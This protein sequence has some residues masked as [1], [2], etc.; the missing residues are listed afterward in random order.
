MTIDIERVYITAEIGDINELRQLLDNERYSKTSISNAVNKTYETDDHIFVTSLGIAALNGHLQCVNFLIDECFADINGADSVDQK[1]YYSP[2]WCAVTSGNMP[3]IKSLLSRGADVNV[4]NTDNGETPLSA[5]CFHNNFNIVKF[6]I[7][8]YN[9]DVE[10]TTNSDG[11]T[12]LMSACRL[13]HA[14]TVKYLVENCNVNLNKADKNHCT[15]LHHATKSDSLKIVKCL[16][17]NGAKLN[18]VD[19]FRNTPLSNAIIYESNDI[20]HYLLPLVD[21]REK[22]NGLELLGAIYVAKE[23]YVSAILHWKYALLE[24]LKSKY[25]KSTYHSS[26]MAII[27]NSV[28][29]FRTDEE[30]EKMLSNT[31]NPYDILVQALLIIDR[32]LGSQNRYTANYTK[33]IA[34]KFEITTSMKLLMYCA[35]IERNEKCFSDKCLYTFIKL[36][37]LLCKGIKTID[38]KEE[39][40]D[41]LL[42]VLRV[43]V[44]YIGTGI[45]SKVEK[46]E[47]F[48]EIYNFDDL[49][50]IHTQILAM[51]F[52]PSIKPFLNNQ[53]YASVKELVR[54]LVNLNPKT[55]STGDTLLHLTCEGN[56]ICDAVKV[57]NVKVIQLLRE[58]GADLSAKNHEGNTPYLTFEKCYKNNYFADSMTDDD[59]LAIVGILTN[60][61]SSQKKRNNDD[62]DYAIVKRKKK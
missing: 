5:A 19:L 20:T 4:V 54:Y 22:I 9:A 1:I 57:P 18:V 37:N 14:E 15:A 8:N 11:R 62:K 17:E 28:P 6:L 12:Y 55:I 16:A 36:Q 44:N 26:S 41:H 31:T 53:Q 59:L 13:G 42:A 23:M 51:I 3:V 33:L 2:L 50:V 30:L 34:D 25:T 7:E 29:E 35:N 27:F 24:R 45:I 47:N 21:E 48:K 43:G 61:V 56:N 49:L 39:I 46:R 60:N 40:I 38:D 10:F 32:I 52:T 58:V